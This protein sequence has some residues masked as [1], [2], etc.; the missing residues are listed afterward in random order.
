MLRLNML[1]SCRHSVIF[2]SHSCCQ[3]SDV[4]TILKC[5]SEVLQ[6]CMR[7]G[8]W[9]VFFSTQERRMTRVVGEQQCVVV[10]GVD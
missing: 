3:G 8:S 4:L 1:T 6:G 5:P 2:A 10:V 9:Q 7:R